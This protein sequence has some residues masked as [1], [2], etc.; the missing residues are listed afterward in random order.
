MKNEPITLD[1]IA[2]VCHETNR[3][4]CV[5]LGDMSQLV[6]EE[7]PQ[8][9]KDSATLGVAFHCNTP[10]ASPSASHDNWMAQKIADGWIYGP[11]KNERDKEHP[12]IVEFNHLPME[13]QQKDV[14]FRLV[15]HTMRPLLPD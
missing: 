14:L 11:E 13:Q 8:W 7:A 15:V 1:D 6:W 5:A 12:C 2:R 10:Y 3:A 4:Y 9:Q